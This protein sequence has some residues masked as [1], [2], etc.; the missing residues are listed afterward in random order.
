MLEYQ[1]FERLMTEF[2]GYNGSVPD[3]LLSHIRSLGRT[4]ELEHELSILRV[5]SQ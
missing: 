5:V 4:D 2:H 1:D 3:R